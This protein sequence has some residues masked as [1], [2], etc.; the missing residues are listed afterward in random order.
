MTTRIP[1]CY[2]YTPRINVGH[3]PVE[4]VAGDLAFAIINNIYLHDEIRLA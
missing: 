3:P 4:A 1:W 2:S